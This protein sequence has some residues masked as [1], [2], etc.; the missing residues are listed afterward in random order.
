MN[1]SELKLVAHAFSVGWFAAMA[2]ALA[3]IEPEEQAAARAKAA[4][5][6][7]KIVELTR[8]TAA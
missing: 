6:A 2:E 7:Q 4:R 3:S 8:T 1:T 5:Y